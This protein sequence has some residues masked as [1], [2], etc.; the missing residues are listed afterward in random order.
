MSRRILISDKI[1]DV[2]PEIFKTAGF[3]V[4]YRP[5]LSVDEL[6]GIIGNYDGLVVRSATKVTAEILEA[7]TN[8]KIIGRAGAGVDTIDVP[9]ATAKKVIVMNT[10]GQNSNAVAELALGMMF[11]LS[12]FLVRG[13]VGL[14]AGKWEKKELNGFELKGRTLGLVGYG[15]IGQLLGKMA[16]GLG[17]KVM[18]YDPNLKAQDIKAKGAEA[19]SLDDIFAKSDIVSLHIPKTKE[20]ANLVNKTLLDKMKPTAYLINCAR[21]GLVDE[22]ALYDALKNGRLAG[23]ASDVFETEPPAQN[24]LF[25]LDNFICTPHIGAQTEE[26]QVNVAVA[27]AKQMIDYFKNGTLFGVV[28]P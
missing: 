26:A 25:E 3:V 18:A 24:K 4:D 23:A 12:R 15:A 10:P 6:K 14:R 2:C 19:V 13:T 9:A 21:G 22:A 8:L 20:T 5:G 16:T 1:E 28:N 7:A 27:V 11:A 17:L